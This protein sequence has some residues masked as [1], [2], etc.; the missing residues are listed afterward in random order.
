M[1]LVVCCC[2][3]MV[4]VCGRKWPVVPVSSM[5]VLVCW[6]TSANDVECN[7]LVELLAL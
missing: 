4:L 2:D 1:G 6:F 5:V 3:G 7:G